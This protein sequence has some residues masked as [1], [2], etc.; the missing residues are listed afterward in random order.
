MADEAAAARGEDPDDRDLVLR[1]KEGD[2]AAF[3]ILVRRYQ[4]RVFA[5]GLRWFRNADDADDVVQETFLRA[6]RALDRFEEDRPLA[7]WLLR[8]A[9]NWAKTQVETRK[10]RGGEELDER[11]RWEGPSPEDDVDAA[12]RREAVNRAVDALPEDQRLVLHLRVS[13]GLSYREISETLDVPIG[14]VMS[15]LSRARETLRAR[16]KR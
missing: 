16:V 1:A 5:M 2:R 10:R 8:I 4:R 11:I 13:E 15:R 6:W 9:S 7:P 14:T 12:R 3:G